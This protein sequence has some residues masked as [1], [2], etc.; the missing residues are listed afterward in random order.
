MG[1]FSKTPE[2][3]AAKAARDAQATAAREEAAFRASPAGQAL[4]ARERG[5]RLFQIDL[6]LSTSRALIVPMFG[7]YATKKDHAQVTTLEAI[8]R[9]GWRL[10]NVGYVF[11]VLGTESRDKFL[12]SGQ[13][14]AVSGEIVGVYLFRVVEAAPAG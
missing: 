13:Q 11:R 4:T 6:A 1:L 2:E 3:L 5:D 12:A 9:Q 14:E 10:E 8:E 7:A